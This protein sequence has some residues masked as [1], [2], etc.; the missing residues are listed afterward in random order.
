MWQEILGKHALPSRSAG[1]AR[2]YQRGRGEDSWNGKPGR[3]RIRERDA[4]LEVMIS[5]RMEER[6]REGREEKK[7]GG[8]EKEPQEK[9]WWTER[10]RKE[11]ITNALLSHFL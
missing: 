6:K 8:R 3:D 1:M 11:N 9:F 4:G 10:E 7:K 2:F 5:E